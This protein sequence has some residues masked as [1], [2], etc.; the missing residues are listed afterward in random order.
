MDYLPPFCPNPS[1]PSNTQALP[2]PANWFRKTGFRPTKVVG[3][4]QR[5]H[6]NLCGKGFSRRSFD[7]DYWTHRTVDYQRI[8]NLLVGGTGLRQACRFLGVSTNLLANRHT[9]L[10]RQSLVLHA[11]GLSELPLHEPLVFDGFE[12]FAHSQF[13]PNNL[14]LLVTAGSQFVLGFNAAVLRRKGRMTAKQKVK[15]D[16]LEKQ[17]RASPSAI[18]RS[19]R[20]LLNW[21]CHLEFGARHLPI[22]IRSD[23]KREYSRALKSLVPYG[24]WMEEGLVDHQT[25]S[26]KAKRT[27]ANPLFPVNYLDRQLR[28]DLAEHVRESVRFA[29]RI[30][31][32]LERAM[33]H[34]AHHNYFKV[35]RNRAK[36][37]ELTHAEKAGID[38]ETISP[39]KRELF[40]DR[41]F[42]WRQELEKWATDIWRRTIRVPIHPVTL[43]AA[44]LRTA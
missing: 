21:G 8:Q 3:P 28:K 13:F 30:E 14:N 33:I 22:V 27:L 1:C 25:T 34:L 32:S 29:R 4:V 31:F 24:S 10:A 11:R 41:A 36:D 39:W 17:W 20:E 26:S 35:F 19:S 40:R 7:I 38:R 44:H 6:C 5:F 18:Y 43:I 12:S 2:L 23:E 42:G 15:R 9:R 37:R 16:E